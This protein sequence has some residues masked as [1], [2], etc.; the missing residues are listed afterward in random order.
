MQNVMFLQA[1]I[2]LG[3]T[4]GLTDLKAEIDNLKTKNLDI[5]T[6]KMKNLRGW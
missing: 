6:P 1:M 4:C 2:R 3:K 5:F